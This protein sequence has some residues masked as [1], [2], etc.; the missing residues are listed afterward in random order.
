VQQLFDLM[1]LKLVWLRALIKP[2]VDGLEGDSKFS[3][4][5]SLRHAWLAILYFVIPTRTLLEISFGSN[6]P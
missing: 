1:F 4:E 2:A 3:S 5:F 6:E